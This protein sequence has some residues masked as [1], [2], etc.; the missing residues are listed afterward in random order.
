MPLK[1][2]MIICYLCGAKAMVK[3]IKRGAVRFR[4]HRGDFAC[5]FC[6]DDLRSES[7]P[8]VCA[9]APSPEDLKEI[10]PFIDD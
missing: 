5:T 8:A 2:D 6:L 1:G 3:N 10:A 4:P 9:D 7:S